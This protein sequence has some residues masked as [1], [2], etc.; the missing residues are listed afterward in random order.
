[1][2][3]CQNAYAKVTG[4]GRSRMAN[5]I[6]LEEKEGVAMVYLNR[7]EAYN[8]FDLDMVQRL[9]ETLISLALD[10]DIAG[11][12]ISGKGKAFCAGG[13]LRW[14]KGQGNHLSK[15]FH[16]LAARFHQAIIEIR[17]MPKPVV[18]AINGLAAGGGFSM[19]LA[20]DFRVMTTSAILKQGYTS[21][22]LSIDGGGSFMLPRL[23]GAAKALE[24]AAFDQPINAE[25]AL[26]W[27][28]VTENVNDGQAVE[29]AFNLISKLKKRSL[30]SFAA[31]KKLITDSF[32]TSFETHLETERNLLS[33]VAG[34]PDGVEG[35][36][37][38]L[39]KRPPV[40][41]APSGK[42]HPS[43]IG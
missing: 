1:M 12:V 27:G 30:T 17:R 24:I 2:G 22:G 3:D 21:N 8:A 10:R 14:V 39:E 36:T 32:N 5:T 29:T 28:L 20:C 35:L 18:A 42:E 43:D 6:H 34:Q 13:D 16:E 23:V 15:A 31:S 26:K 33:Y 40:F 41:E 38:F 25:K 4:S 9:A 37:A 11:V 19:A 7:P